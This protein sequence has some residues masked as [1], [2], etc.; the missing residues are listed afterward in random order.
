MT[1]RGSPVSRDQAFAEMVDVRVHRAGAPDGA[2]TADT[3]EGIPVPPRLWHVPGMIPAGQVTLLSGD[4]GVGKSILVL[5]LCVAT[6]LSRLWI[7]QTP[8]AGRAL[9]VGAEDESDEIH[10]RLDA[11]SVFYGEP[12]SQLSGLMA[13]PLAERE[14][15]ALVT[16]DGKFDH[17]RPT[18]L[19]DEFAVA[20][21]SWRPAIVAIDASA[22]VF[23][24]DENNRG[25]VRQFVGMLRP[26]AIESGAAMVL[27]SHPSVRGLDT[28]SGMSGSTAWN[29]SVRSRLYFS[30]PKE[31]ADREADPDLRLLSIL[32]ANYAQAGA[33]LRLRHQAGGFVDDAQGGGGTLDLAV[34][35]DRVDAQFL[36]LLAAYAAQRRALSH[37][38]GPGYAPTAFTSDPSANGTTKDGFTSAMN[39]LFNA[40]KI[41]VEEV[42]P[43]SRRVSR[44]VVTDGVG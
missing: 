34:A 35:R 44:I 3:L 36:G 4:G 11:L 24:A 25:H 33:E 13:W 1:W 6:V 2:F 37:R 12:L 30:R 31:K 29:N 10:R 22:D 32:K 41:M 14:D 23:A 28:G 7:G 20:V 38:P 27:L 5:Q 43:P 39:R 15:A 16:C 19:W 26:L 9:Y 42:G 8:R 17:L 40:K 21:R 18:P